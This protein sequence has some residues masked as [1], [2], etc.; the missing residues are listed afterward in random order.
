MRRTKSTFLALLAVLLLPMAADADPISYNGSNAT[1]DF[2][3]RPIAGGPS[4]SGLGPVQYSVQG[5]FTDSAGFYDFDSIQNYDGYIHVYE[6]VF[7][8]LDQLANL[9][10]GDDDGPGGIGTSQILGLTLSANVQYFLVSSAFAAGD[11]G[12]FTNTIASQ[13]LDATIGLGL[14]PVPEPCTLALLG[15]GLLGIGAARRNKV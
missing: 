10:A 11:V 3:D 15:L 13:G 5:F 14:I 9:L 8:P 4:I 12:T 2:W 1:G 6:G 7:D